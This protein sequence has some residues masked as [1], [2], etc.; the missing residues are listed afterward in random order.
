MLLNKE[1]LSEKLGVS[2]T[3]VNRLMAKGMPKIKVGKSVRFEYNDVVSWLKE[4]QN[5]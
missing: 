5:K 3:T 1:Q 4:G 2:V